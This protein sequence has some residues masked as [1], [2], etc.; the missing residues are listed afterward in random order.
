M[1]R[2]DDA[3]STNDSALDNLDGLLS[4][5]SLSHGSPKAMSD[6]NINS[7]G[8][9]SQHLPNMS[10]MSLGSPQEP[11]HGTSSGVPSPLKGTTPRLSHPPLEPSQVMPLTSTPQATGLN[12]HQPLP[13]IGK[14]SPVRPVQGDMSTFQSHFPFEMNAQQQQQQPP[15]PPTA[16]DM[17]SASVA[18]PYRSGSLPSVSSTN[19]ASPMVNKVFS[20]GTDSAFGSSVMDGS[21]SMMGAATDGAECKAGGVQQ[22]QHVHAG[23]NHGEYVAAGVPLASVP[24]DQDLGYSSTEEYQIV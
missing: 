23:M 8:S 24:E 13:Q 11:M 19:H 6:F 17:Y 14:T 1:K 16:D 15:P 21:G 9:V 10:M 2:Y 20:P 7:P 4:I 3:A 22:R 18:R 5:Q 12:R